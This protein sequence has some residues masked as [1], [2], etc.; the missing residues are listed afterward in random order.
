MKGKKKLFL[1][2]STLPPLVIGSTV[3]LKN[4]FERYPGSIQAAAG[5]EYGARQDN[6]FKLPFK[7]HYLRFKPSLLQRVM[8]KFNYFHFQIILAFLSFRMKQYNPDAV[9]SACTPD[10]LFFT[11]SYIIAKKNRLPFFVQMHDLW[12]ENTKKGSFKERLSKKYEEEIFEYSQKVFCMT[13]VQRN[14][15]IN[16]YPNLKFEI[17]PHCIPQ[18]S[19]NSAGYEKGLL[20]RNKNKQILYT[21]N[22]SRAMNLDALR[23]LV[24]SIEYLPSHFEIKF[25]IALSVDE[26]KSYGIYHDRIK[27]DWV[28]VEESRN[29]IC[30]ADILFLP[31]SF[32]NCSEKEVRTVYATKT[33]DYLTSGVPILVF[34]PPDSFHSIDAKKSRWGFVVEEDSAMILADTFQ[35]LSEDINLRDRVLTGAK[36]EIQRRNPNFH[37]QRLFEVIESQQSYKN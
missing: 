10:G 15:Y 19:L 4:I 21:G 26:C 14:F 9:F 37:A 25:L 13:E 22:I 18:E 6:Q 20:T 16:K 24:S 1:V 11:A 31:L 34:S 35:K 17:L 32:K 2:C 30:K 8:E 27:Y 36:E 29:L 7:T 5:W 23:Q 28:S 3:L 12:E 33:L